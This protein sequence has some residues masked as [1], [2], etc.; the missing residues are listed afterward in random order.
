MKTTPFSKIH[1]SLNAKMMPF[2]GYEMPISYTSVSDEHLCV[3][4]A[5]GMFDVSHMGEF[6]LRGD[7]ALALIQRISSNDAT[8]LAPGK[9]QYSCLLNNE[10][11]IVD[12]MLVYQLQ[13]KSYMLVVNASNVAK[14]WDWINANN[15]EGVDI[16]N[17]TDRT[18][19]LAVQGPKAVAAIQ[20]L[21]AIKVRDLAYYTFEKGVFAGID[22]VLISATGY[23]GA[24]GFEIYFDQK[25]GEKVWRKIMQAGQKVGIQAAGLG[26]RDTL[27]LEKGYCL[28]GNEIDETTN[29]LEAGLGWITKFNKDFNAKKPLKAIKAVGLTRKLVGFV[30]ESRGIARH[31]Y[32]IADGGGET[33]GIVT[34]GTFS[35]SLRR[36]IGM[37]YVPIEYAEPDSI[38]FIKVRKKLVDARVVPLP[39]L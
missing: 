8:K 29:P 2:A 16:K 23:T 12:D 28:Y 38:I 26:A 6:I 33:I 21:T 34:S 18:A 7:K 39:F 37:G 5:V 30:I 17:I 10:G 25:Y 3:R 9:I 14:D 32:E 13:E 24:G 27:R 1:R 19:L 4:N 35:P 31:G 20:E 22:N 15:K 11:G 36:G